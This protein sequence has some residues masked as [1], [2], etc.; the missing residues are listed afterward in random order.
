MKSG[1]PTNEESKAARRYW[2]YLFGPGFIRERYGIPPNAALNYGY[3]ILRAA[4]ARGLAGSGL[5]PTIGIHHHNKYNSYCLADDIMEPYRPYVDLLVKTM[6]DNDME[7]GDLGKSEKAELLSLLG[8]D[9]KIGNKK[10]PLMVGVSE[11]TASLARVFSG[12]GKKVRYP[13]L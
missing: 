10:R 12:V 9:I 2:P 5:H 4:I 3:A 6:H 7:C 13:E 8:M 11:T 1:D